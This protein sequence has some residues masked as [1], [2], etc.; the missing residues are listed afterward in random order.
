MAELPVQGGGYIKNFKK[1][2]VT[3]LA[4]KGGV[5][6]FYEKKYMNGWTYRGG[7]GGKIGSAKSLNFIDIFLFWR[8]L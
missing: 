5:S 6:L 8:H 1:I 3:E 4:A 2:L 7:R